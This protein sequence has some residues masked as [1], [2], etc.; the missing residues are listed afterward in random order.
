MSDVWAIDPT[1]DAMA[2]SY[3]PTADPLAM[4]YSV[5]NG[6][7]LLRFSG[8]VTPSPMVAIIGSKAVAIG[9]SCSGFVSALEAIAAD[10]EAKSLRIVMDSPGGMVQGV[11]AAMQ[12]LRDFPKPSTVEV[13]GICASAAYWIAS[14]ADRIEASSTARL[15]CIGVL[16]PIPVADG[17]VKRFISSATPNKLAEPGSEADAQYQVIA[18]DFAAQMLDDIGANRGV[19]DAAK[20]FGEGDILPARKALAMGLIDGLV[21]PAASTITDSKGGVSAV[22]NTHPACAGMEAPVKEHTDPAEMSREELEAEL[23]QLREAKDTE[24]EEVAADVDGS[25]DETPDNEE[26]A[27]MAAASAAASAVSKDIELNRLREQLVQAEARL[28]VT[29]L[30]AAQ[31]QARVKASRVEALIASGRIGTSDAE[32]AAAEHLYDAEMASAEAYAVA[33]GCDLATAALACPVRLFS[34]LEAL[35]AGSGNPS[36]GSTSV[37]GSGAISTTAKD[38]IVADI[39]AKAK[40]NKTTY[41]VELAAWREA[42]PGDYA[43][44][45][46]GAK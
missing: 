39:Y 4:R 35:A 8:V 10:A 26:E 40:E 21:G 17:S 45:F 36:L 18:D 11:R 38:A 24:G 33:N 23:L 3:T 7:A 19:K 16:L 46:G 15:G 5:T 14:A 20:A 25:P 34:N 6:E 44:H 12:A 31:A 32:K 27:P 29:Q 1:S 2:K 41:A 42:N 43:A 30:H 22:S 37:G 9:A 13:S 28:G